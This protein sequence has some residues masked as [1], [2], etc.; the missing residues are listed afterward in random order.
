MKFRKNCYIQNYYP[1]LLS[2]YF[3]KWSIH[4]LIF[5]FLFSWLSLVQSLQLFFP[6]F[7][8]FQKLHLHLSH[9]DP[10]GGLIITTRSPG[11]W[12]ETIGIISWTWGGC[13]AWVGAVGPAL[14]RIISSMFL[15]CCSVLLW[16]LLQHH[17][18]ISHKSMTNI[19]PERIS[20]SPTKVLLL[21]ETFRRPT[22]VVSIGSLTVGSVLHIIH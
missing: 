16:Y 15:C 9:S 20:P 2:H 22:F 4:S 21:S 6:M 17:L 18:S 19:I 10:P 11:C 14:H 7:Q 12:K 1:K 8:M 5:L 13:W 3:S